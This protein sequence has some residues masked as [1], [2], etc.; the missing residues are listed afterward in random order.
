MRKDATVGFTLIELLVVVA[1][2]GTLLA[3]ITPRFINARAT[4]QNSAAQAYAHNLAVWLASAETEIRNV[5]PGQFRGDCLS[6]ELQEQGAPDALPT[7]ITVCA[8][9]YADN[10]YTVTVTSMTGKGGPTNNGVFTAV[11]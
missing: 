5:T 8:I 1:I 2:M 10:H 9:A 11:Y 4:A 7:S 3:I 6:T